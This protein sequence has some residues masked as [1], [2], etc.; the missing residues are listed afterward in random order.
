VAIQIK[1]LA[2][3]KRGVYSS[4]TFPYVEPLSDART[5]VEDFFN[6]VIVMEV[7]EW[8]GGS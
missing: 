5:P 4:Y 3:Q 1:R 6:R 2:I 7:I 8:M